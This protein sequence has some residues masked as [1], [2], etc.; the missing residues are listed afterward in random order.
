[1]KTVTTDV[2]IVGGGPVGLYLGCLLNRDGLDCNIVEARQKRSTHSRSIG[3]HPPA[4]ESLSH[5]SLA[6]SVLS[7]A[8]VIERGI[9]FSRKKRMGSLSFAS[10]PP[11]FP[12]VLSIPQFETEALLVEQFV[13]HSPG[14]LWSGARAISL[15]ESK[16]GVR[17]QAEASEGLLQFDARFV[18]GCDGPA[19]FVRKAMNT[20]V[21]G[22]P[23]DDAYVMGDFPDTTEFSSDATIHLNPEGVV[24]SFPLPGGTRRWVAWTSRFHSEN[25]S[26]ILV[27]AVRDRVGVE[28]NRDSC[29]MASSFRPDHY[30]AAKMGEGRILLAGDAAHVISP[31][32][33]QGM[34]LG[35]L[36][37]RLAAEILKEA[38]KKTQ[39]EASNQPV[40]K[41][42]SFDQ[43]SVIR[44]K[45]AETARRRAEFNMW[46]GRPSTF[47]FVKR[48][49]AR[50]ILS[51]PLRGFFARQFTM[52]GL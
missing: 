22:G 52:R 5:I 45:S 1:M 27:S 28:L 16:E 17:V 23:Y 41:C 9:A 8:V 21:A 19:S 47:H 4:L 50:A 36:D 15:D 29:L 2:L 40:S 31:I 38:L 12:F 3:I 42:E 46:M 6:E 44:R 39:N 13:H 10:C 51:T 34:N 30:L 48:A 24:E 37:A 11:P 25:V 43:Y 7:K 49:A 14:N 18:V 26:N 32:G 35:W 33:G 20:S